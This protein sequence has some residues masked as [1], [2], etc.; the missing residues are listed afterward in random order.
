MLIWTH[1]AQTSGLHHADLGR[2][3]CGSSRVS[4]LVSVF[5][6]EVCLG[7]LSEREGSHSFRCVLLLARRTNTDEAHVDIPIRR[8]LCLVWSHVQIFRRRSGRQG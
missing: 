7:C 5:S 3:L 8:L 2:V 1:A 6:K 4:W